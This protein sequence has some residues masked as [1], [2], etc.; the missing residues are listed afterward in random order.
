MIKISDYSYGTATFE[1]LETAQETIRACGPDFA[2]TTLT[3][4]SGRVYDETGAVIGNVMHACRVHDR[5]GKIKTRTTR[6]Y[7]T[8]GEA[9]NAAEH[10]C[11]KHFPGDRGEITD[12]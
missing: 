6:W 4:A 11:R 7:D 3:L 9:Y 12:I 10:L 2:A 5:M 1:D 8:W